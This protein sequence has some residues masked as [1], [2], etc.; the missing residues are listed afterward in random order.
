MTKDDSKTISRT[1]DV[2]VKGTFEKKSVVNS[3]DFS[4]GKTRPAYTLQT[5]YDKGTAVNPGPYTY[6][7]SNLALGFEWNHNPDNRYWSLTARPGYLRLTNGEIA[8]NKVMTGSK[9]VLTTRTYGPE[10]IGSIAMDISKMKNGDVAGIAAFNR[11][12]AYCGVKMVDG[13]KSI[14]YRNKVGDDNPSSFSNNDPW[15]ETVIAPVPDDVTRVYIKLLNDYK[16][17]GNER[18]YFYYSLDG[19]TWVNTEQSRKVSFGY[20]KHFC[21]YRFGVFNFATEETG[22]YVDFDYFLLGDHLPQ[23]AAE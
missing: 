5:K 14:I 19:K 3:T 22:G 13:K 12:Y 9:N 6:N 7:G 23:K 1:M 21:G 16:T 18:A 2:P 4:N 10:S 20:P 11:L 17:F 8:Q 15:A